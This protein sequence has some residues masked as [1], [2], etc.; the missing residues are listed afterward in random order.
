MITIVFGGL[1]GAL[2]A[3][4]LAA[5]VRQLVDPRPGSLARFLCA[6]YAVLAI[7]GAAAAGA[8]CGF[9]ALMGEHLS[10]R[11]DDTD[12]RHEGSAAAA[13]RV[14]VESAGD[15]EWLRGLK[16][17]DAVRRMEQLGAAEAARARLLR[18]APGAKQSARL[19]IAG[20]VREQV[21]RTGGLAL[22]A[23]LVLGGALFG[24]AAWE[25]RRAC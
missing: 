13:A 7:F 22:G 12:Q 6:V 24:L 20:L 17:S 5:L 18:G 11:I 23:L 16:D 1:A 8:A 9:Y 4:L 14:A 3:T 25:R 2:V 15:H 21:L 19:A 10:R